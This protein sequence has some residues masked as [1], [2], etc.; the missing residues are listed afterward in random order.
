MP[1][2]FDSSAVIPVILDER[3]S[4]RAIDLWLD[5]RMAEVAAAVGLRVIGAG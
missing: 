3:H 1:A 4:R 2:Y 5:A